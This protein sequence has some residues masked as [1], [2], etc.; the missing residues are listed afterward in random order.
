[1]Q[2]FLELLLKRFHDK[3][4]FCRSKV[5]KVFTKLTAENLVPQWMYMELFKA[6][7]ERLRDTAVQ[8]RKTALRLF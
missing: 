6:V 7:T 3:S 5:M 1:M 8:V 4:A 2:K